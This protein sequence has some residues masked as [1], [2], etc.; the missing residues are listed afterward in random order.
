MKPRVGYGGRVIVRLPSDPR[1]HLARE[2]D[3]EL[4]LAVLEDGRATPIAETVVPVAELTQAIAL[5]SG[6]PS[7]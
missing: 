5:L 1:V 7:P 2:S 6:P 4:W 3:S